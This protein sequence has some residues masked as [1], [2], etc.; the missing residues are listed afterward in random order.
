MSVYVVSFSFCARVRA[1]VGIVVGYLCLCAK[2][3]EP[4]VYALGHDCFPSPLFLLTLISLQL[5]PP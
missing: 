1:F 4:K 2:Q 3:P 5:S